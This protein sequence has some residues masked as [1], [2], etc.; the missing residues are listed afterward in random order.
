MKHIIHF[1]NKYED[2]AETLN[3]IVVLV[4]TSVA[5]LGLAPVIMYLQL[6]F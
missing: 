2:I 6:T 1:M 4:L 5:I 3:G